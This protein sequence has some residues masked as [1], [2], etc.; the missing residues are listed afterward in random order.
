MFQKALYWVNILFNVY[1][2]PLADI[3]RKHD[4][5]Y[6]FYPVDTQQLYM[7]LIPSAPHSDETVDKLKNCLTD[8]KKLDDQKSAKAKHG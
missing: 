2:L 1:T 3:V 8:I 7:S 6:H 4:V 5:D